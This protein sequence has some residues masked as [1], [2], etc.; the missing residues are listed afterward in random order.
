MGYAP[1]EELKLAIQQVFNPT[2]KKYIF[3]PTKSMKSSCVSV[4]AAIRSFV[5][6]A[7]LLKMPVFGAVRT[8]KWKEFLG[9]T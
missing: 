6:F 2:M 8:E 1:C 5:S 4:G 7:M 9:G 3:Y